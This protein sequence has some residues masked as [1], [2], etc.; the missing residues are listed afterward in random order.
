[1]NKPAVS[2]FISFKLEIILG[3]LVLVVPSGLST[4]AQE[5]KP[6]SDAQL[7]INTVLTGFWVEVK[8]RVRLCV[9]FKVRKRIHC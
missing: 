7:S 6:T 4:N 8:V 2:P 3:T 1:M 5:L 9:S